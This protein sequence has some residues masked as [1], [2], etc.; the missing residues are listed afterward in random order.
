MSP[1]SNLLTGAIIAHSSA[2]VGC[3]SIINGS[4]SYIKLN[5]ADTIRIIEYCSEKKFCA[6][7]MVQVNP[8]NWLLKAGNKF[9]QSISTGVITFINKDGS[10]FEP[11]CRRYK[12]YYGSLS[13]L[14]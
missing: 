6:G 1:L 7:Q 14:K 2:I 4:L 5:N 3:G 11:D 13:L 9:D 8:D 10:H 12:S